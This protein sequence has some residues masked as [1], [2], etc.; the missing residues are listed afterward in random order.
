M[1]LLTLVAAATLAVAC[2]GDT[3]LPVLGP[4]NPQDIAL[5]PADV[6]EGL[7][8]CAGSGPIDGYIAS[9]RTKDPD[10]YASLQDAWAAL[11]SNGANAAAIGAYVE[12]P[13]T[14]CT[15]TLGAGQGKSATSFVIRYKDE[16]SATT[17]YKRGLLNFPTPQ[18]GQ[19]TPGLTVGSATG[20]GANSW[21]YDRAVNGKAAY[22]AFWQVK[23][24]DVMILTADLDPVDSR[25][26]ADA[27][28]S[29]AR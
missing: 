11:K 19:Q 8:S 12:D 28:Y 26:A 15:G 4:P 21:V 25:K 24:F 9:L 22:L 14:A 3:S 1:L 17:A 18:Q 5:R 6:P 16:G 7:K 23:Q 2:N 13:T 29:R 10:G 20:L 27:V